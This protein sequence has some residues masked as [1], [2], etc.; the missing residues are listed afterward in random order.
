ML[1]WTVFLQHTY[2]VGERSCPK[3]FVVYW[4]GTSEYLWCRMLAGR[5]KKNRFLL[6]EPK[7]EEIFLEDHRNSDPTY[8][9]FL[10]RIIY[11][12]NLAFLHLQKYDPDQ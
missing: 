6:A 11:T 12:N 2:D 5:R 1:F 8:D 10:G 4:E 9:S 7:E 3:E